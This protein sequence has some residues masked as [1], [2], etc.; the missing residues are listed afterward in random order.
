MKNRFLTIFVC[1]FIAVVLVAG[2]SLGI[3]VGIKNARAA[4]KYGNVT[5]DEGTVRYFASYYKMLYIRSLRIA[6]ID[7]SDK[8]D[9]WDSAADDGRTYGQHFEDSLREYLASLVAAADIYLTYSGYTADDKLR[10]AETAEEILQYK[11]DGSVDQFNETA[12]KYGFDYND[13]LNAAALMYKARFAE[14]VIYGADGKNLMNYPELCAEYLE[15]YSHVSL[16][17]VRL[18]DDMTE[19][20]REEKQTV[21]DTLTAAIEA[22]NNGGDHQIT[23]TMFNQYLEDSDGDPVMYE[24]GYYFHQNAEKTAEF[25]EEFPEIVSASLDME[26]GEYRRVECSI[27]YCFIYKYEQDAKAYEDEDNIFLSDFLSDGSLYHYEKVLASLSPEVIFNDRY[28][29]ID[30]LEIP[31]IND[32]YIR[33][34]K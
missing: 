9:F 16:L 24:K 32:Y 26:I 20:V 18:D 17:F 1:V 19:A 14:T 11:A 29:E 3:A 7:A 34:F 2:G 5:L 25:A 23:A 21:I 33:E 30:V 6:G 4:V 22:K 12:V 27:G 13:F 8:A 28:S 31:L 15:S 10:V